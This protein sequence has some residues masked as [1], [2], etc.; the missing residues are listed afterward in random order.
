MG[1]AVRERVRRLP[2]KLLSV[3]E[4]LGLSQNEMIDRLGLTGELSQSDI[5]RYESGQREPPLRQILL[6]AKAVGGRDVTGKYLEMLIDD[7]LDL[8]LPRR[9]PARATGPSEKGRRRQASKKRAR[10]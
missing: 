2:E 1:R 4:W 8:R 7:D 10:R 3:R 6:Y 5:S 9:A